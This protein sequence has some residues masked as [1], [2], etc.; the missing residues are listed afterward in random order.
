MFLILPTPPT[1]T[2][3][4]QAPT[5]VVP[6]QLPFQFFDLRSAPTY[7]ELRTQLKTEIGMSALHKKPS[8]HLTK[9]AENLYGKPTNE[10]TV[11]LLEVSPSPHSTISIADIKQQ[12][13]SWAYCEKCHSQFKI[14]SRP[15]IDP[16]TS[17]TG[18]LD[19][20]PE[21]KPDSR[22]NAW[23]DGVCDFMEEIRFKCVICGH[24]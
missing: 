5:P 8:L 10:D 2:S 12:S 19:I 15:S 22:I 17:H 4:N 7:E 14:R 24:R 20:I 13:G 11:Q 9:R 1:T 23:V 16:S 21:D 3:S 6:S 18:P